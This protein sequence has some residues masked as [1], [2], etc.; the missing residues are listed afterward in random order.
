MNIEFCLKLLEGNFRN[1]ECTNTLLNKSRKNTSQNDDDS[2]LRVMSDDQDEQRLP[3][4][5]EHLCLFNAQTGLPDVMNRRN[6]ASMLKTWVMAINGSQI[7][8]STQ[9]QGLGQFMIRFSV[10]F[11][12]DRTSGSHTHYNNIK[13]STFRQLEHGNNRTVVS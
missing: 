9:F 10:T 3:I 13:K 2:R 4:A 1:P 5:E 11:Q 7:I 8:P 12:R 6:K